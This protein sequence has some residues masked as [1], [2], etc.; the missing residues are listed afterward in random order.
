M[1][2]LDPRQLMGLESQGMLLAPSDAEGRP[3]LLIPE[4]SVEPGAAVH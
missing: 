1:V 4:K 3:V 2:N